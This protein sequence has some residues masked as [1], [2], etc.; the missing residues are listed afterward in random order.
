MSIFTQDM[1]AVLGFVAL[2]ALLALRVPIGI[3]LGAVGV[4]GL[5]LVIGTSPAL[6]LLSMSPLASATNLDFAV[7]PLF[8]LMGVVVRRAGISQELFQ[9]CSAWLGRF[10]GGL[11]MATVG[12]CGLFGAICGSSVA[13]AATM[14]RIAYPEM[15]REGY[16][17]RYA[18]G[19]IAA[20]GTL[21]VLIPPSVPMV[22]YGIITENDIGK[23]FVAGI[24]PGIVAVVLY[25]VAVRLIAAFKP[26]AIPVGRSSSFAEKVQ[27]LRGVWSAVVIFLLV[28]GGMY[29]GLFT[30]LEA[31][32]AGA[33]A[34]M[35]LA[36]MRR[37]INITEAIEALTESVRLSASLFVVLIGAILFGSFLVITGAPQRVSEVLVQ[38]PLSPLGILCV[39]LA[40]FVL[41]GAVLDTIAMII[42]AVPIVY[43][44]MVELGIDPIWFGIL[45][46][47]VSEI[48]L[49]T[50][51]YGMNVF[52][53]NGTIPK[54]SIVEVFRGVMPFVGIDLLRL[55]ILVAFPGITLW[56]TAGM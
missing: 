34:S 49:I 43:P 17:P 23:L 53:I 11:A 20:G 21:G 51:P 26:D 38:L 46:V 44:T 31:A 28:I 18:A 22:L 56:L 37:R 40:A 55:A 30:A 32:A 41:L 33:F 45:V 1:V 24:V 10:R 16:A 8:I 52:V 6:N 35:I 39:I 7:V 48:G 54:V 19:S 3:S 9:A 2:F 13:T 14:S 12:A 50:P 29:G 36:F 15:E 5:G 42:I 4:I 47:V 25:F 27:S